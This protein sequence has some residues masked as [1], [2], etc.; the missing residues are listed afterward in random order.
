MAAKRQ[1]LVAATAAVVLIVAFLCAE[2][3]S[4][5]NSIGSG[6]R[7]KQ[8]PTRTANGTT[9]VTN[10]EVKNNKRVDLE[11]ARLMTIGEYGRPYPENSRQLKPYCE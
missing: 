2:T 7:R 9:S 8:S 5:S 6:T 10:C 4:S 1:C 11:M 3:A